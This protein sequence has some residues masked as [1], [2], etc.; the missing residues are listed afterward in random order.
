MQLPIGTL[1]KK[2]N[3]GKIYE[4]TSVVIPDSGVALYK[5]VDPAT[6][7]LVT[8]NVTLFDVIV[9]NNRGLY[10]EVLEYK[11]D[12]KKKIVTKLNKEVKECKLIKS[13]LEAYSSDEEELNEFINVFKSEKSKALVKLIKT[14]EH[15][16]FKK[17]LTE[18][19]E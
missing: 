14:K 11:I 13:N 4:V 16:D 7:Q 1:I 9:I 5:L 2:S 18:W 12:F 19:V 17:F 8:P 15:I 10:K 3:D 6:G